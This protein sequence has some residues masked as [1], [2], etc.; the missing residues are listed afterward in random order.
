[1][2]GDAQF[3]VFRHRVFEDRDE[4]VEHLLAARLNLELLPGDRHLHLAAGA[5]RFRLQRRVEERI[6]APEKIVGIVGLGDVVVGPGLEA[7]DDVDRVGERREEDQRNRLPRR[8]GLGDLAEL[9][10]V[11]LRHLDVGDNEIG[12]LLLE[13]LD[14]FEAVDRPPDRVARI[15]EALLQH[16]R[17]DPAV[18]GD[19]DI[20]TVAR[21]VGTRGAA[22]GRGFAHGTTGG[23]GDPEDVSW[24]RWRGIPADWLTAWRTAWPGDQNFPIASA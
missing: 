11:H 5:R 3:L 21:A 22:R 9:V 8:I 12:P 24:G 17:L 10:A 14:R 2:V 18:L 23:R 4:E 15:N 7:A 1:M 19:E 20:D 6:H 13:E 16:L